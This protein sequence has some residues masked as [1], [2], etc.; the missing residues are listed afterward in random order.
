MKILILNDNSTPKGGADKVAVEHFHKFTMLKHKTLFFSC[1]HKVFLKSICI[2]NYKQHFI[3]FYKNLFYL[4]AFCKLFLVIKKFKPSVIFIHSWTKLLSPSIFLVTR[5]FSVDLRIL[6]HDYFLFCP[7]GGL[8]NYKLNKQCNLEG[9][10]F[11][12]L[13]SNCDKKSYPI[14]I[15]RFIRFKI[16]QLLLFGVN[17][18][19]YCLND[20]QKDLALRHKKKYWT[21]FS[22]KNLIEPPNFLIAHAVR[23]SILFIGRPDPEKGLNI[24]NKV[25]IIP[26]YHLHFIG[27]TENNFAS[28]NEAKFF[29][30]IDDGGAKFDEIVSDAYIGIFPSLWKE[31]DG[32]S[33]W[34]IMA[35]GKP[36]ITLSGN[37]FGEFLNKH[38][39]E[40]VFESSDDLNSLLIRLLD[41]AFYSQMQNR[42]IS[43]YLQEYN[44]RLAINRDFYES[45]N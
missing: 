28:N 38:I 26:E 6:V 14:K 23:K 32:L 33:P 10:S 11:S 27:F 1:G 37:I 17:L 29:G 40:L 19:L 2:P 5:I 13:L 15:F 12:C 18:T 8:Y 25:K 34:R 44:S 7:N 3:N 31:A 30:W 9:G 35:N 45:F 22:Y 41:P 42:V 24:L 21:I 43:L 20:Y 39:P 36:V 4:H 16:Q